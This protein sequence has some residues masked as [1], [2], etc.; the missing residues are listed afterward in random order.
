VCS[1][2][3]VCLIS[4]LLLW[5]AGAHLFSCSVGLRVQQDTSYP[6]K[7]EVLCDHGPFEVMYILFDCTVLAWTIVELLVDIPAQGINMVVHYRVVH[8]DNYLTAHE[9]ESII[10]RLS[11]LYVSTLLVNS[12]DWLLV[13]TSD[14]SCIGKCSRDRQV[15]PE[16]SMSK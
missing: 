2:L 12:F 3:L 9:L 6:A 7:F 10:I 8:D 11:Q 16:I 14:M 13:C 15:Y 1:S 4:I 5:R